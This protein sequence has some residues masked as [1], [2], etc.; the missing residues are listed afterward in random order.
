MKLL[1]KAATAS[2]AVGA[3]LAL[4]AGNA[5]AVTS[6]TLAVASPAPNTAVFTVSNQGDGSVS[7]QVFGDGPKYFQTNTFRVSPRAQTT[8]TMAAIPSGYYSIG[9]SCRS[10]AKP[11]QSLVIGGTAT[12]SAQPHQVPNAAPS[13]PLPGLP[14]LPP[15]VWAIIDGVL[16][17]AGSS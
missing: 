4:A 16:E 10:F 8:V 3:A 7:C 12:P 17:A 2:V 15:E 11:K 14:A 9:W 5:S 6:E 13:N 1:I